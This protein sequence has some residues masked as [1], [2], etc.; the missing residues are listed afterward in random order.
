MPQ[1][2]TSVTDEE[3]DQIKEIAERESR[4]I[5][6]ATAILIRSA[7]KERKRLREKQSKKKKQ[8]A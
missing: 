3:F 6:Q 7:L 5:S 8:T 2:S 4:N 1:V